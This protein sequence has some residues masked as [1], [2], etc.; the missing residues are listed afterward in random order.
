METRVVKADLEDWRTAAGEAAGV[1]RDGGVVALPTETV[2]GL[3]ADAFNAEAV[4]KVFEVK[5]RPAFDPLIVHLAKAGDLTRVAAVPE[6]VAEV[7]KKLTG[8]FWP[9][10][11]TLVLPKNPEVPDL[12]TSG[13]PTVAVRVSK[14]EV[15]RGVAKELGNP[16]A[17]PSA[18][19]FGRISPTSASAVI[20]ELGGRIPLVVD[21]GACASGLESTIVAVEPAP[22]RAAGAK[23]SAEP[24]PIIRILRPG[25]VT[26]EELRKF[27]KV[28][29]AGRVT[30]KPEAPG[31]LES[32]YAPRTPLLLFEKPEDF[33]P[34]EGKRYG[35]LSYRGEEKDG[36]LGRHDWAR[37]EVMSPGSG[38]IAEAA[39]RFFFLLRQLDESGLDAIVAEPVSDRALGA[40]VMDR[41]RRA[42]ARPHR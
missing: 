26:R 1:L 34:E 42:A 9:G 27:G 11:L 17:A 40:A 14:H 25:P 7:V 4:A 6:D 32:H 2:Y 31:G 21:G 19:L 39:V 18:N 29:K 16:I 20:S 37:V 15:M 28:I 10:P 24:K 30:D 35:L 13:L 36:Y 22:P 38:K 5:E 3:A 33:V 8:A 41:L 23:G 12:V